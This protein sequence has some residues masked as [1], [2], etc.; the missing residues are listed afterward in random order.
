MI[1]WKV[2]LREIF[3]VTHVTIW[4]KTFAPPSSSKGERAN[5]QCGKLD[6]KNAECELDYYARV[7]IKKGDE[8]LCR[9]SDFA[10]QGGW[11]SFGLWVFSMYEYEYECEKQN[12]LVDKI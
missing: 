12:N 6:D 10:A 7:D 8:I 1:P 4:R 9:Y 11:Q 3:F 2:L 5:I